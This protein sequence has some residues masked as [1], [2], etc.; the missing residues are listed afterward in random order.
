MCSPASARCSAIVDRSVA[1]DESAVVS[2]IG[3]SV[4]VVG[5]VVDGAVVLIRALRACS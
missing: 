3:G 2:P 5:I 4:V 1:R